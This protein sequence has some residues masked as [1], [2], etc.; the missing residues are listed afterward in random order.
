MWIFSGNANEH[1][2]ASRGPGKSS[3]FSL[4]TY[5]PEIGLSGARVQW[6][7]ELDTSVESGAFLIVLEN[8]WE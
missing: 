7:V 3:L 2:D 5:N 6:L 8:P 4:T 1:G